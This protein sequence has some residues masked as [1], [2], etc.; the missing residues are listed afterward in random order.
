GA[1]DAVA[2]VFDRPGVGAGIWRAAGGGQVLPGVV[3]ATVPLPPPRGAVVVLFLGV[4]GMTQ[5]VFN[6][7]I[8]RRA[9][10]DPLTRQRG[11][12]GERQRVQHES[13]ATHSAADPAEARWRR[14]YARLCARDRSEAGRPRGTQRDTRSRPGSVNQAGAPPETNRTPETGLALLI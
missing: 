13:D 5:P 1:A 3:A 12:R 7:G 11:Q 8:P 4:D 2:V 10:D 14:P 9:Q 6:I